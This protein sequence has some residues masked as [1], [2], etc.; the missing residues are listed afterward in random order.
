VAPDRPAGPF[1]FQAVA[2]TGSKRFSSR[3]RPP[4]QAQTHI[5]TW[6]ALAAALACRKASRMLPVAL[7]GARQRKAG[8]ER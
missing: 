1:V 2:G 4:R 6:N 7:D 3:T 5:G 8:V